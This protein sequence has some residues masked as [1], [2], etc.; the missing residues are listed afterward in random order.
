MTFRGDTPVAARDVFVLTDNLRA[1]A[2]DA[3]VAIF[4]IRIIWKMK[5]KWVVKLFTTLSIAPSATMISQVSQ[6]RL[7]GHRF[8]RSVIFTRSELTTALRSACHRRSNVTPYRRRILS[9]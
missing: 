5:L 2:D 3:S 7:K 9:P 4:L 8:P 1:I 6:P